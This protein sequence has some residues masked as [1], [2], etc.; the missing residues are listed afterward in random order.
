M[1]APKSAFSAAS[2]GPP[3]SV[4]TTLAPSRYAR[5]SFASATAVVLLE[6]MVPYTY[7]GA[8][9]GFSTRQSR[10]SPFTR[11]S[12]CATRSGLT[13]A[14]LERSR[15]LQGGGAADAGP[16]TRTGAA[17]AKASATRQSSGR[18]SQGLRRIRSSPLEARG[19]AGPHPAFGHLVPQAGTAL[20]VG[21]FTTC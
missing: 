3:S 11:S 16:V 20:G 18:G 12:A 17:S 2:I 7:D 19:L 5:A 13:S 15:P 14:L 6:W 8:K 4:A 9:P 1:P 21:A 10:P